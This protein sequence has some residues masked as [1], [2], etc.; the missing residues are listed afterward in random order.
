M[1]KHESAAVKKNEMQRLGL[2]E[3]NV[4]LDRMLLLFLAGL[5]ILTIV[6]TVAISLVSSI[7]ASEAERAYAAEI[8]ELREKVT[9]LRNDLQRTQLQ[10]QVSGN[11][12]SELKALLD[13]SHDPALQK[14]MLEQE[15]GFQEFIRSMK[16]GIYDLARIVPGSRTWLQVY[17]DKMD[18]T[19]QSSRNRQKTLQ[20]LTVDN[21]QGR[22]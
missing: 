9:E 20:S 7:Y 11:E 1:S 2:V 18:N 22:P 12:V 5:I 14:L 4:K 8:T 16:D 15:E 3:K 6:V 17:S 21:K 19:L 13:N 10:L